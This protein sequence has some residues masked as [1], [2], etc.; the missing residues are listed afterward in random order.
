MT[1]TITITTT[2]AVTMI[3]TSRCDLSLR[4]GVI[5]GLTPVMALF[6]TLLF[7]CCQWWHVCQ[8]LKRIQQQKDEQVRTWTDTIMLH[9]FLLPPVQADDLHIQ[10]DGTPNR[11]HA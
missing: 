11:N 4:L 1:T 3:P 2:T 6:I 5:L 10:E 7:A 8:Q 9:A